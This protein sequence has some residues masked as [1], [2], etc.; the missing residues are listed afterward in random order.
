[1]RTYFYTSNISCHLDTISKAWKHEPRKEAIPTPETSVAH[2]AVIILDN[3]IVP[4]G[5]PQFLPANNGP[6]FGT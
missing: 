6:Q 3:S 1:M 5:V 4:H 2:V